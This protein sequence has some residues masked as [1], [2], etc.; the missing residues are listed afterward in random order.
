MELI[1]TDHAKQRMVERG[2]SLSQINQ[3][4]NFPDYT[5]RKEDKIEAHK[6]INKR[7]LKVVYFQRGKF[8]KIIT[9][10]WK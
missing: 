1:L 2:I 4:I 9:L 8:I 3:T 7:L 6:E 10:I 5:I